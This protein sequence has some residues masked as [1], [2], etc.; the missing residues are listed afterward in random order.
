MDTLGWFYVETGRIEQ[1]LKLL[2]KAL[3][4]A[5]HESDIRYHW[6]VALH[7]AGRNEEA[8]KELD[9]LLH[10]DPDFPQAAEARSLLVKLQNY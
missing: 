1:G 2:Q 3:D 9:R 8:R 4:I 10:T 5:L 6:A 7:R